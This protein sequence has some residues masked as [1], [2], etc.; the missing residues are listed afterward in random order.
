MNSSKSAI[1]GSLLALSLVCYLVF[2]YGLGDPALLDPDEGRSGMIAKDMV[3]SGNWVTLTHHGKP[4]Y[5]KPVLYFWL[6]AVGFSLLGL[7]EYAVRFPSALA[8]VLTV[9]VIYGWGLISGEWKRGLW[10]GL[11]LATSLE[12][13]A[14]ARFGKM[15]MLFGFFFTAALF[16]FLWWKRK[17]G[18][19][20]D[21][22]V[23]DDEATAQTHVWIWPFYVFL[24]LASLTKG[25][26]GIL[27][28]LLIV[29]LT[30]GLRKSWG[31]LRE[32]HLFRGL[33]VMFLVSAPWYLWAGLN[34]LDYIKTF[35]WD[36]NILR[37]FASERSIGHSEPFY[38]FLPVLLAG[39]IP[40]SFFLPVI[41][42]YIWEKRK[43][44]GHEERFFLFVWFAAVFI[45]F[46]LS[47]NKLGTY[48]L[49]A[50]PPLALLTG[51]FFRHFI[52]KETRPWVRRWVISATLIWL[53]SLLSIS[54]L[55][56]MFLRNRHPQYLPIDFPFFPIALLILLTALAWILRRVKWTPWIV[57][58]SFLWLAFW[59]F[60]NKA[61]QIS[62][63]KSTRE[64]ARI[65]EESGA[66]D[67]R[68][69]ILRAESFPFY[70]SDHVQVVPYPALI[71]S[72]LEESAP[73]IALIK[74]KHLGVMRR[75]PASRFFV[76]KVIPS[77]RALVANFPN[78]TRP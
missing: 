11:I 7:T 23:G 42:H 4:Y 38:Y 9:G 44:H 49:P 56:E 47:R 62:E 73:T 10:G 8:A 50:F 26:V 65:V 51:D 72:M 76:W 16:Y 43:D 29:G 67:Y 6:V 34:D 77:G 35:L 58:C 28:P 14:L 63:L 53:V 15:D 37:F 70:M 2:F 54:P 36:H 64:M 41:F 3:S 75:V 40:W 39:F 71:E 46:S 19:P 61:I 33:I 48:I 60:E 74:E 69:V 31:L 68:V 45:F 52:D 22:R 59:F 66:K 13:A 57:I 5:D 20:T 25:P 1:F 24:A 18:F 17:T 55:T 32:M 78:P 30:L 27:L 21:S 12:F